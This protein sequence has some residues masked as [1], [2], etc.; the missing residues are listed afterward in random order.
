M[1]RWARL[2]MSGDRSSSV[3]RFDGSDS[4]LLLQNSVVKG[5]PGVASR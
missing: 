1:P 2:V 4:A 3:E 5:S